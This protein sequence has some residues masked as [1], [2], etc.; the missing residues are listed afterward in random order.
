MFRS[1]NLQCLLRAKCGK[2]H[3]TYDPESYLL[4][5]GPLE[6][7]SAEIDSQ[8]QSCERSHVQDDSNK[9][10]LENL[11]SEWCCL[12]GIC[13]WKV[14][15]VDWCEGSSNAKVDVEIP[16]PGSGIIVGKSAANSCE[17]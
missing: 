13:T 6:F 4:A 16:P 14:Q 3:S 10:K 7:G 15:E 5:I 8:N 17:R 2:Y 12:L 11:S 1:T 9:V